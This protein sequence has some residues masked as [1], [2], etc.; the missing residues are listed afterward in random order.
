MVLAFDVLRFN[1]DTETSNSIIQFVFTAPL[2]AIAAYGTLSLSALMSTV[3]KLGL[4]SILVALPFAFDLSSTLLAEDHERWPPVVSVERVGQ[5]QSPL[6]KTPV[7]VDNH[8]RKADSL[9]AILN[10]D[11]S[12]GDT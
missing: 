3:K 10:E 6:F 9:F 12:S 4:T 7:T 2:L 11:V 5:P 8:I 1:L